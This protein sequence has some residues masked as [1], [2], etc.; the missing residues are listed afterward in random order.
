M[1]ARAADAVIMRDV[2]VRSAQQHLEERSISLVSSEGS[3]AFRALHNDLPFGRTNA[4]TPSTTALFQQDF[5]D[6]QLVRRH[7]GPFAY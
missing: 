3:A 1:A 2:R 6:R 7:F 5:E 4:P